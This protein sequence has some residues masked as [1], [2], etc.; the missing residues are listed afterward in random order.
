MRKAHIQ[1]KAPH[2][3]IWHFTLLHTCI[4]LLLVGD[5]VRV[6][7]VGSSKPIRQ[8]GKPIRTLIAHVL[9]SCISNQCDLIGAFRPPNAGQIRVTDC[10]FLRHYGIMDLPCAH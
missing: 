8:H 6:V 5:S 1:L 7:N 3:H 4:T 2:Q 9:S 10:T